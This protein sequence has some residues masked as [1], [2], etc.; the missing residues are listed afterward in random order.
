MPATARERGLADPFEPI[1]ALKESARFLRELLD[2]FGNLGLAAAAYN[3]GPQRVRNWLDG[4]SILPGETR[5][6]VRI[7][8]GRTADDWARAGVVQPSPESKSIP[9]EQMAKSLRTVGTQVASNQLAAP[10]SALRVNAW[11][12]WGLQLAGDWSESRVLNQY[13]HLQ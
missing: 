1:Q 8:T 9:C 3:G 2:Q 10:A 5:A 7:I 4:S 12:P 13:R 6:Y 11:K